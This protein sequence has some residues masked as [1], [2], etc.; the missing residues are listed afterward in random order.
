[1]P[2]EFLCILAA[3]IL[4]VPEPIK[5]SITVS[6]GRVNSFINHS[7]RASGK[8]ALWFLLLHSVARFKTLAG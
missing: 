3:T 6:P 7:G 1:M 2:I 4:V 5:G 8:A